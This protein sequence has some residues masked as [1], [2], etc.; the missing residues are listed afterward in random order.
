MG[1]QTVQLAPSP[2]DDQVGAVAAG[3]G[4][5]RE[6][7]TLGPEAVGVDGYAL[8]PDRDALV[9]LGGLGLES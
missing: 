4:H 8:L 5:D 1:V 9:L 6:G 7:V 2:A 3:D